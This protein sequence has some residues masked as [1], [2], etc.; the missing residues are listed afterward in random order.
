M[1]NSARRLWTNRLDA[2][3]NEAEIMNG[4][5]PMPGALR[6]IDLYGHVNTWQY[7]EFDSRISLGER[8]DRVAQLV[9][10]SVITDGSSPA[11]RKAAT[12][13]HFGISLF[14]ETPGPKQIRVEDGL[15]REEDLELQMQPMLDW[16]STNHHDFMR[17]NDFSE[18]FSLL[19]WLKLANVQVTVIDMDGQGPAIASPDRVHTD[20]G[21]GTG[22]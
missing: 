11:S 7:F 12:R 18:A 8:Q 2:L 3:S 4:G 17:L 19:R 13:S 21:P 5:R 6:N 14:G 20:T 10:T 16:L 1:G 15:Y 9:V 22:N